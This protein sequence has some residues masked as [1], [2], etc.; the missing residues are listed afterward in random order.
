MFPAVAPRRGGQRKLCRT[1][2]RSTSP[3]TLD[4]ELKTLGIK[5]SARDAIRTWVEVNPI[6]R[7]WTHEQLAEVGL[8]HRSQISR[9]VPQLISLGLV[10][11]K[12]EGCRGDQPKAALFTFTEALY[13]LRHCAKRS[14]PLGYSPI[15]KNS[16]KTQHSH[17]PK[18]GSFDAMPDCWKPFWDELVA[19]VSALPGT[20]D[21]NQRSLLVRI[22]ACPLTPEDAFKVLDTAGEMIPTMTHLRDPR[23]WALSCLTHP[24]FTEQALRPKVTLPVPEPLSP[25]QTATV[26][27]LEQEGLDVAG[28]TTVAQALEGKAGHDL[29]PFVIEAAKTTLN[30]RLHNQK[31]RNEK[32]LLVHLLRQLDPGMLDQAK[33]LRSAADSRREVL[34]GSGSSDLW[35]KVSPRF[36]ALPGADRV[37]E[38]W[39]LARKRLTG[40]NPEAAG[41][42]D[43]YDEAQRARTAVAKLAKTL[44]V[45]Q[46]QAGLVQD[47]Q[48]RIADSKVEL[49]S[50]VGQRAFNFHLDR[51]ALRLAGLDL[52]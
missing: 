33:R 38:T 35:E 16:N 20:L 45:D 19:K 23:A 11:L 17:N 46:E 26:Q 10:D 28:A 15:P 47:I 37:L 42:L 25:E 18:V 27:V 51:A 9:A 21:V 29:L 14:S 24:K 12:A 32:G 44:L 7:D 50:P 48:R 2:K 13:L 6:H 39:L 22:Q 30:L 49:T 1:K 40:V 52:E 31:V 8:C 5:R 34:R 3:A 36:Q 4:Q 41:F 43:L